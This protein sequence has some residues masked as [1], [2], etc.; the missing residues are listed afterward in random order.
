VTVDSLPDRRSIRSLPLLTGGSESAVFVR[1]VSATL[2]TRAAGVAIGV[3]TL[4]ATTRLL[5]AAGRGQFAVAMTTLALILQLSNAGLHSSATYELSRNPARRASIGGLLFWYAAICVGAIAACVYVV[6]LLDPNILPGIPLR[7]LGAALAAAPPAMFLMLAGNALLGLGSATW[8]NGLDLGT[9]LIGLVAL[10]LFFT[11]SIVVL[12]LLYA[13]LHFVVA[14]VAYLKLIGAGAPQRPGAAL[15]GE[16]AGFAGRIFLVNMLMFLVLRI[17]LFLV[18]AWLGTTEAG[19]YSVA[20]QVAEMLNLL[21]ASIAAILFP[22]LTAMSAERRWQSTLRVLRVTSIVLACVAAGVA[23]VSRPIFSILFGPEFAPAVIALWLLL[24]GLWCLG[25]NSLLHQH[26]AAAGMPWF[27]VWAT[28]A[29]AV[30]NV[31]LNVALLPRWGIAGAS[32]ASSLTYG[33]LL[34][35]T[36]VYLFTAA[37]RGYR[38]GELRAG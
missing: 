29:G 28:L 32:V 17:D 13:A 1:G 11:S 27:L 36:V 19:R 6:A 22:T 24:P 4:T 3:V 34:V 35:T 37:G 14:T 18:N 21:S 30:A 7:V 20:T 38:T 26:L 25:L 12:L 23:L 33:L 31:W 2:L 10:V 9:K 15:I 5:G 8:F 16:L